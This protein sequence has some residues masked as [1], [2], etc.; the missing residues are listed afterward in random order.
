M[1]ELINIEKLPTYE[2]QGYIFDMRKEGYNWED[3]AEFFEISQFYVH[4]MF[5][6]VVERERLGLNGPK[7]VRKA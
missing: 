5:N 7:E 1:P 6:K 3:I 2:L 4:R